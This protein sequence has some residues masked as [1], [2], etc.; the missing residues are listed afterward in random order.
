LESGNWIIERLP[1]GGDRSPLCFAA[2]R[3]TEI[4]CENERHGQASARGNDFLHGVMKINGYDRTQEQI[5]NDK[6]D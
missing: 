4:E 5:G 6:I 1:V 3:T 2:A